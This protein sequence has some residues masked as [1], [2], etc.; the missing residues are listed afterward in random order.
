MSMLIRLYPR[1]WRDR[2]EDEVLG[3]LEQRPGSL[4]ASVDLIR[5]AADAH[6]HPQG[7]PPIPWT[8]RLPGVVVASTGFLWLAAI[9]CAMAGAENLTGVLGGLGMFAMIIGLPGDYMAAWRRQILLGIGSF[10]IAWG[11]AN[12]LGWE[13]GTPFA[14]AA[15]TILF[16]GSLTLAGVRAGLGAAMRWGFVVGAIGLPLVVIA[17]R[18]QNGDKGGQADTLFLVPAAIAW[19]LVGVRLAIRGSQTLV[20]SPIAADPAIT[21]DQEIPA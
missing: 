18:A 20:D 13:A 19:L 14:I 15:I 21:L 7:G 3:L 4:G 10:V 2:Y 12:A 5:G 9:A 8:W 17:V 6:L 11:L 16:G 1:A